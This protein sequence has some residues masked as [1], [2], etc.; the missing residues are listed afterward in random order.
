[1]RFTS[2]TELIIN[3][4][5]I[6][7]KACERHFSRSFEISTR[8]Y[9]AAIRRC[10]DCKFMKEKE[11]DA[12]CRPTPAPF[13]N[14]EETKSWG[15]FSGLRCLAG[16]GSRRWRRRWRDGGAAVLAEDANA[17]RSPPSQ[18][19]ALF[20]VGAGERAFEP[21]L[22]IHGA[23][24]YIGAY[25]RRGGTQLDFCQTVITGKYRSE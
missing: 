21:V 25:P 8:R 18:R 24:D 15:C 16:G 3:K 12:L 19:V 1:M 20:A 14:T 2:L 6:A 11:D 13:M 9:L 10:A 23:V 5:A 4:A 22:V 7:N 17:R